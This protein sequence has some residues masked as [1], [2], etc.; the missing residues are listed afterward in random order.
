M[1]CLRR[2]IMKK[3]LHMLVTVLALSLAL[4]L[5][6]CNGNNANPSTSEDNTPPALTE[7]E[8]QEAVNTLSTD[9][10]TIQTDANSVNLNDEENAKKILE[11]L[12]KPFSDF[13]N[14]NPPE[15]YAEAHTKLQ[16][17]CQAM[18]DYIDTV[19]GLIGETDTTKLQDAN[20]TMQEQLQT[21]ITDLTEGA[22][23][24]DTAM[25]Q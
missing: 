18:I 22:T 12:K 17:G 8:Y 10:S 24:L 21:A 5:S 15:A 7:E 11:D 9:L 14:V 23:M 1:V 6:A 19:N 3:N 20:S 13:M 16:S 25:N 2:K 4:L